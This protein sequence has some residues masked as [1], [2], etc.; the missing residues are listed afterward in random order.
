VIVET[1]DGVRHLIHALDGLDA[2][3]LDALRALGDARLLLSGERARWL[4]LA[5]GPAR[6]V[7]TDIGSDDRL[8][9]LLARAFAATAPAGLPPVVA[10]DDLAAALE[11]TRIARLAPAAVVV[12]PQADRAAALAGLAASVGVADVAAYAADAAQT[13]TIVADAPV[14]LRPGIASR[15][16]VF[17]GGETAHDQVAIVVG[18]PDLTR[19]VPVRL[20]SACLTGD[21]F[22]SLKCDCGDQLRM[23]VERFADLGGGVV[24]YLDQEGRGIGIANKMRA[25][26]LQ[27]EGYDTIDA[28]ARLGFHLDERRWYDAARMLDLL[29]IRAVKLHSNN[30]R[31]AAA[32]EAAGITVAAREP[33]L[34]RV[35]PENAAYLRTK[36]VRAGHLIDAEWLDAAEAAL[37][38]SPKKAPR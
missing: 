20:H 6:A 26:S 30:P 2:P 35:T 15:F 7:A 19:P 5:T 9:D 24:L 16:V 32:L 12:R 36:A 11:L 21:L 8:D 23:A 3:R 1:A 31:K 18:A 38:S 34:A 17:R 33:V 29:G 25:Y 10:G 37:K 4:G 13:I 28:D 22:G 14:P 27:A